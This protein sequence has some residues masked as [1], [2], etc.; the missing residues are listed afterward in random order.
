MTVLLVYTSSSYLHPSPIQKRMIMLRTFSLLLLLIVPTAA[1]SNGIS[2]PS[3]SPSPSPPM[4][5]GCYVDDALGPVSFK[6]APGNVFP[7]DANHPHGLRLTD[8][9][10][11]CCAICQLYKNCTFWTYSVG[12][13]PAKPTCYSFSGGCCFL[14]TAAA[15]ADR[16]TASGD[17]VSGSTSPLPSS[18]ISC[19][20]GTNCGGTNLW[21]KW[22]DTSL[23]NNTYS[24]PGTMPYPKSTD[25]VDW[26]F[27]SGANPGYG[28]LPGASMYKQSSADTFYPTWAAD[29]NLYTGFTDGEVCDYET[30]KCFHVNSEPPDAPPHEPTHGQATIV[31]DDPFA[32]NITNVKTFSGYTTLPYETRFP[33]GLLA[34]KGTLWYGT[35][36]VP[37]YTKTPWSTTPKIGPLVDYRHSTDGGETWVEP[38]VNAT[39]SVE[40]ILPPTKNTQYIHIYIYIYIDIY[41]FANMLI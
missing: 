19:R 10:A 1:S 14:K 15:W 26:E 3:P 20:N 32:L 36:W 4:P 12:G 27:K 29:N 2:S 35:Y 37:P 41:R 8:S 22:E 28:S 18:D 11:H 31:G 9:P 21:T 6:F 17:I 39:G 34:Y 25:L 23:P 38:R 24:N 13:T 5:A 16:A 7:T 33:A 40:E 30:R